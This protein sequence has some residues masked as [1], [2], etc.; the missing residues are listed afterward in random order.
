MCV[1]LLLLVSFVSLVMLLASGNLRRS[2][3]WC[4]HVLL[5]ESPLVLRY[6]SPVCSMSFRFR[7]SYS[8]SDHCLPRLSGMRDSKRGTAAN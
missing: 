5:S 8:S 4:G 2:C 6:P 1:K 3:G 7:A